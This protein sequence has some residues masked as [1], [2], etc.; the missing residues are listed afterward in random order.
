MTG[1]IFKMAILDSLIIIGARLAIG[2]EI[3][4]HND[5]LY[6]KRRIFP[7]KFVFLFCFD[8]NSRQSSLLMTKSIDREN[9]SIETDR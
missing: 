4:F 3:V 2:N 1:R 8:R 6:K 7:K 9:V 5:F